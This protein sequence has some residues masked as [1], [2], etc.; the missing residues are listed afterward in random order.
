[1]GFERSNRETCFKVVSRV[2]FP[3]VRSKRTTK[4]GGNLTRECE[5]VVPVNVQIVNLLGACQDDHVY[6]PI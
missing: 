6:V 5:V 4:R 1:M 3:D 2:G